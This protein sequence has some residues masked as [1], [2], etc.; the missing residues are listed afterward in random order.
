MSE[1]DYVCRLVG[2]ARWKTIMSIFSARGAAV[3]CCGY[4]RFLGLAR[5]MTFKT[6]IIPILSARSTAVTCCGY[7]KLVGLVR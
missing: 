5:C 4:H 7:G 6:I 1:S 2:L 3:T